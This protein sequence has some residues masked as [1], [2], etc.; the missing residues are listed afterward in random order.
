[1]KKI[2]SI[3]TS[4]YTYC[5]IFLQLWLTITIT[6]TLLKPVDSFASWFV[7][8]R[9]SCWVDVRD[10]TEE[11]IMH[12]LIVPAT[13]S[14]HGDHVQIEVFAFDRVK[15]TVYPI[16]TVMELDGSAGAG[17]NGKKRQSVIY[18]KQDDAV[19]TAAT[20]EGNEE[21]SDVLTFEYLLKLKVEDS[22]GLSNLEYIMDAKIL[23]EKD[24]EGED[25]EKEGSTN[26]SGGEAGMNAEFLHKQGCE[27]LRAFGKKGDN[28]LFFKIRL[29]TSIYSNDNADDS[30]VHGVDVVAAWA[31]GHEAVTLTHSIEFRPLIVRNDTCSSTTT[32]SI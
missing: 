14:P 18:I 29:P 9:S 17:S 31:C 26:E 30:N 16:D 10:T 32:S 22:A 4:P 15:N 5:I 1:M 3:N 24:D 20:T 13:N 21:D 7:T 8:T 2:R 28:G 12:N 23:P 6:L 11:V 27:N 19:A 25:I